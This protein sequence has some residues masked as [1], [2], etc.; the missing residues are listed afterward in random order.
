MVIRGSLRWRH[1]ERD[2]VSNHQPHR[3]LLNRLFKAQIKENVKAPSHWPLCWKF[4]SDRWIPS[5]KGKL[6]GKCSHLITS[7]W[8]TQGGKH[9][10][11]ARSWLYIK[12]YVP[13]RLLQCRRGDYKLHRDIEFTVMTQRHQYMDLHYSRS[14]AISVIGF[15]IWLIHWG[16][17]IELGQH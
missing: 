6:L 7:S 16:L 9:L 11:E 2:G 1:S 10:N 3:C 5:T 12:N 14:K 17:V 13:I 15:C 8:C 4:T